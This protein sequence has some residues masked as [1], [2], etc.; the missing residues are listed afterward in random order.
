MF[1]LI[2]SLFIED[3]AKIRNSNETFGIIIH[4]NEKSSQIL[5]KTAKNDKIT[6]PPVAEW[7][8]ET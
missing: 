3:F 1:V 2:N 4:K 6:L 5:R 8:V 7:I